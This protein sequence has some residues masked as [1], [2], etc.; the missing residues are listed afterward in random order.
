MQLNGHDKK[1]MLWTIREIINWTAKRFAESGI[2]TARLDAQLLLGRVL[3]LTKIQLYMEMDKPLTNEERTRFRELIK[4]RLAGEPVAYLLNE[5]YWHNLKLY[6][7][8]RVLIPRP[9]TESMLD[10]VLQW[11]KSQN[12]IPEIVFDFCTGSG[13]LAIA[14]AKKFP[15]AK[16]IAIDISHDALEVAQKNAVLNDVGNIIWEQADVTNSELYKILSL[17]YN[18]ADIIVANPP[19]VTEKEWNELDLTVK[20]FEPKLALVSED[21]GLKI[22]KCIFDNISEFKL[23]KQSSIFAMELAEKQPQKI[24]SDINKTIQLNHPMW[25]IPINEYFSLCDYEGKDRFLVRV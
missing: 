1:E 21:E 9:E 7:D 23:L 4:R 3:N 14:L 16:I 2:E 24:C 25:N 6:V 10:F 18:V 13:C 15:N 11:C 20:D 19:Y 22:G 8:N 17:E 12:K 5:K